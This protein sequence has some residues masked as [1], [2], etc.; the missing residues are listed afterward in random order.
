MAKKKEEKVITR[1]L[2]CDLTVNETLQKGEQLSHCDLRVEELE[3]QME[4][5]K[6]DMKCLKDE[7]SSERAKQR[8]LAHEI[9]SQSEERPVECSKHWDY[10]AKRIGIVRMDTGEVVEV[11]PM[12][13]GEIDIAEQQDLFDKHEKVSKD[14]QNAMDYFEKQMSDEDS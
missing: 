7:V 6:S 5:V 10:D 14:I 12:S 9:Q 13:S 1:R 8:K 11:R 2:P 3:S 4:I